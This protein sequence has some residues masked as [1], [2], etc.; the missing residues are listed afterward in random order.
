MFLVTPY[1]MQEFRLKGGKNI[2]LQL[3]GK[4]ALLAAAESESPQSQTG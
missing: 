2:L 1:H 3:K 4:N